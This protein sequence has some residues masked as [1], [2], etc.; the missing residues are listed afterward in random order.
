MFLDHTE[1]KDT[2]FRPD[3]FNFSSFK[4]P[5]RIFQEMEKKKLDFL[6]PTVWKLYRIFKKY[7]SKTEYET[8]FYFAKNALPEKN[9]LNPNIIDTCIYISVLLHQ[10]VLLKWNYAC[11][12]ISLKMLCDL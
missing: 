2:Y 12:Y 7:I 8:I 6:L 10:Y 5:D 1:M 11:L 3:I 4:N 9:A